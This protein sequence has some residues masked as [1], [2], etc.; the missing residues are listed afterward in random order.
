[1]SER[2]E[3]QFIWS[4]LQSPW[5]RKTLQFYAARTEDLTAVIKEGLVAE[6]DG[7]KMRAVEEL[8]TLAPYTSKSALERLRRKKRTEKGPL[9]AT[10]AEDG[11]IDLD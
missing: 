1:L 7:V 3:A 6:Y 2:K 9:R 11:V 8:V 5:W 10:S 4:H